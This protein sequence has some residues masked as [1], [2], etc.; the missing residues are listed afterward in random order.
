MRFRPHWSSV[1]VCT[2]FT[3]V[4]A[5]CSDSARLTDRDTILVADFVN[6]TGDA[7]FDD[8]LK[9]VVSIELQQTPFFTL[10]S[11]QRAQRT[12]RTLQR[13]GDEAV[14]GDVAREVCQ[15][16]GATATIEGEIA[17]A[18]TAFAITLEARDCESGATIAKETAQAPA[19]DAVLAATGSAVKALRQRLGEPSATR[20]TYNA[21]VATAASASLDAL[22][23]YG[24][25]VRTRAIRGDDAAIPL[26]RDAIRRDPSFALAYAKL[27]VVLGN[28]GQTADARAAARKAY[29]LRDKVTE[30]ERL[31]MN[32]NYAVRV[33]Q[34]QP[35]I[36]AALEKLT[37]TYPRD[38]AARNNLGVYYNNNGQFEDA[39]TQYQAASAIAPD[40][41][42]PISNAAY[43]LYLLGRVD[44]GNAAVDRALQIRPESNLAITRWI[45]ALTNDHPRA[46]EFE[47]VARALAGP[48]QMALADAS[49]AAWSGRFVTFRKMQ[50]DLI[51]RLRAEGNEDF[52]NGMAAGRMITLAAALGGRDLDA[53]KAAAVR[54]KNPGLLVQ[55]VS[56]LVLFDDV[57]G[58]RSGLRRIE[59]IANEDQIGP[60]LSVVRAYLQAHD[61]QPAAAI[62]ALQA[63]LANNPR[64][65]DLHYFIA[66]IRERS[67]DLDGAIAGYRT[68]VDSVTYLGLNPL[69]PMSR[70]KLAKLLLKRGDTA[71]ATA[72]LDALLK[73][74]KNAEGEFP[75]LNEARTLRETIR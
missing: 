70:L 28:T 46:A 6:S 59:T 65:R 64:A 62:A 32:W 34:D 29:E 13:R 55:Q 52:A 48:D 35:A 72:Q 25:G 37:S 63:A 75:A 54:E 7:A 44:E 26:F 27:G 66:R 12:M 11:D 57:A 33:Q 16:A 24:L 23:A 49:L 4:L 17:K 18:G 8:A 9:Q 20:D 56:A 3:I 30:Y 41:P 38:F 74:W 42:G 31:Y 14:T 73:Q 2:G 43:T 40:D 53:L 69:I 67:G 1:V 51:A 15:R 5:G 58:V 21:T 50:D 68:V 60:A 45:V 71:G 22:G 61:G 36:K 39:L 10:L 47:Q 19:K